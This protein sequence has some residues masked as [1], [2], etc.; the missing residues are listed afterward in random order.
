MVR[1]FAFYVYVFMSVWL[2]AG[3]LFLGRR[4]W[5]GNTWFV[6]YIRSGVTRCVLVVPGP[7][8][9]EIACGYVD[10]E[11]V[12]SEPAP[13]GSDHQGPSPLRTY[14]RA[15]DWCPYGGELPIQVFAYCV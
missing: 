2:A 4:Q 12:E 11:F 10:G 5:R 7:E 14:V 9:S 15:F 1:G 8:A 13:E 3:V 6:G